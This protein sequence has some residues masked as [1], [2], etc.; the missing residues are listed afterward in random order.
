MFARVYSAAIAG[1]FALPVTVDADVS[2]GLPGSTMVGFVS[3][4]VREAQERVSAALHNAGLS[5]PPRMLT[6]NLPPWHL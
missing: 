4:Q 6:T 3:T 1:V 5:L 2:T